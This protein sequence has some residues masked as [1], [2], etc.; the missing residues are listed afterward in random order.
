MPADGPVEVDLT[1]N[2][3]LVV[4]VR[5]TNGAL[6]PEHTV[7][8]SGSDGRQ[9][10]A[11]TGDLGEVV[12][13]LLPA[14][15][16]RVVVPPKPAKTSFSGGEMM[17]VE[18][19]SGER[20][21]VDVTVPAPDPRFA[22][23]ILSQ[24]T[25]YDGW[26]ARDTSH[27]WLPW[28]PVAADGTV[29]IDIQ[30]SVWQLQIEGPDS[31]RWYMRIPKD[32]PDAYPIRI[33][34]DGPGYEGVLRDRATGAPLPRVRV[35]AAPVGK[36]SSDSP[37]ASSLTDD[38]GAFRLRGLP[39]QRFHF[40][41]SENE[42]VDRDNPLDGVSFNP[43]DPPSD[44]PA[45]LTIELPRR[46][47]SSYQGIPNRRVSGHVRAGGAIRGGLSISVGSLLPSPAGSLWLY[48]TSCHAQADEQGAYAVTIPVVPRHVVGVWDPSSGR[49]YP[50]IDWD[51]SS[52]P[53]DEIRD[54]DL[55]E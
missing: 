18:L 30:T 47:G 5:D 15:S 53:A 39:G 16:Y 14:G 37:W 27:A 29:P 42:R 44:P 33:S 17:V 43:T 12:F 41:F 23:L 51:G 38:A 1:S 54:I 34:L 26:R 20:K 28:S 7:T 50:P 36:S 22:R 49:S 31:R 9:L 10:W 32:P 35:V 21:T 52:A 4:R 2:T 24:P 8:L 11:A 19:S 6:R 46:S 25:G 40:T 13:A 3:S 48:P 45:R 55:S